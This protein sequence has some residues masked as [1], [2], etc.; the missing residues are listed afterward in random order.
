MKQAQKKSILAGLY[1]NTLEWFDFSLYA[2]FAAVFA[3]VFFP[4]DTGFLSLVLAFSVFAI[5]FL[6]RPLGGAMLGHYADRA[7]RRK[8]LIVSVVVMTVATFLIAFIPSY[9]AIGLMAPALFVLCRVIQGL[10]TGGELPGSATFLI[11]HMFHYGRGFAGSLVLCTAF[12]G[13]F[14][15]SLTAYLL[16][17]SMTYL[18][19][20]GW[21]WRV[22]Y[23]IGGMLGFIGIY[24]R[25]KS[26]ESDAFKEVSET[27]D[28]PAK[29]VFQSYRKALLL[30]VLCTS[31]LAIGNYI[32]IA[33]VTTFLVKF[34][35]FF[36]RDALTVNFI[37]LFCLTLMIPVMGL[38]SDKF[39]RKTIFSVGVLG[40]F[41]LIFPFFWLLM[42]GSMKYALVAELLLALMLAP[43]N[44][45]VP[46]MIAEMFPTAVRASGTSLGYNIGQ[47]MFGG[48]MPLI[49]L[50]LTQYTQSLYAPAWYV[51][52]WSLLVM[53]SV[54]QLKD[55]F[56]LKKFKR[57]QA[58]QA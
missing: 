30:A 29:V 47:A 19:F 8:A 1:G 11:E 9:Q 49:A 53:L 48:T 4:S 16:S 12:L 34:K 26:T 6:V 20:S 14:L 2:S 44:A 23:G 13:I 5:G 7:G 56:H 32:L 35:G 51:L 18:Q 27:E 31:I 43:I 50:V 38:L 24:L 22:A 36:Y 28:A 39:G 52:L 10:A 17:I 45:T 15:G 41:G 21:G 57:Q 55:A 40:M 46:T 33:Y 25:Y 37:A 54:T 3:D 42:S 58:L